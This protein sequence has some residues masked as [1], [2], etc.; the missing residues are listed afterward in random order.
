[1]HN[2]AT[3]EVFEIK[4]DVK[5]PT[6]ITSNRGISMDRDL[7]KNALAHP[8]FRWRDRIAT[9]DLYQA[10]AG[11][12]LHL[13]CPKCSNMST[14]NSD[15]KEIRWSPGENGGRLSIAA[16]QCTWPDCGLH[17]RVEDNVAKEV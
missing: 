12:M 13:Y 6:G 16:F 15:K 7:T 2:Q 9:T 14:I 17:I 8:Q 4:K 1:M 3:E 10:G 5:D 11:L